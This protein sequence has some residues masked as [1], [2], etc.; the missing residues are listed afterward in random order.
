VILLFLV[1]GLAL[2]R[3]KHDYAAGL[4]FALAP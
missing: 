3:R 2:W 4:A 1:A